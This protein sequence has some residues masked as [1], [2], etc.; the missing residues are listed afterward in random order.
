MGN[1]IKVKMLLVMSNKGFAVLTVSCCSFLLL[2]KG[3]GNKVLCAA[4]GT[5][6]PGLPVSY[7]ISHCEKLDSSLKCSNTAERNIVLF[8]RSRLGGFLDI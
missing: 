8:N 4:S 1:Y 3:C 6:R 7:E 2:L 5:G